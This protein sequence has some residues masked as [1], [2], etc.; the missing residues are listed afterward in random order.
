M[1]DTLHMELVANN[2]DFLSLALINLGEKLLVTLIDK[3]LLKSWEEKS[4]RLDIPVDQV[5]VEA[6]LSELMWL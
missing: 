5:L 1:F 3:D 4:G 6:S 2:Y